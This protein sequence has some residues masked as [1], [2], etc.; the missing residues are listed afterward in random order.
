MIKSKY[1]KFDKTIDC[2][3]SKKSTCKLCNKQAY[4]DSAHM[5]SYNLARIIIIR[6]TKIPIVDEDYR[7]LDKLIRRIRAKAGDIQLCSSCHK[8]SDIEQDIMVDE[9][10]V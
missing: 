5:I 1:D 4:T 9:L 2:S 6:Q 3:I 8:K 10:K 7:R